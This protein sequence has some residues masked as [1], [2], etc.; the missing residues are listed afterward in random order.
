MTIPLRASAQSA[1][2]R[3]EPEL[4]YLPFNAEAA[5]DRVEVWIQRV[6][7]TSGKIATN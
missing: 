7:K 5:P 3:T 2:A 1:R 6:R 4:G